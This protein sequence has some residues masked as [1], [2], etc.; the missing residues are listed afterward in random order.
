VGEGKVGNLYMCN[1]SVNLKLFQNKRFLLKNVHTL[2][3]RILLLRLYF[4]TYQRCRWTLT[5][6][7]IA[8]LVIIRNMRKFICPR[9]AGGLNES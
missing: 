5:Y 7:D 4:K 2:L 1:Y 6:K 3:P 9:V 8:P